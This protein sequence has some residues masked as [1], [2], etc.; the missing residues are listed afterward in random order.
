MKEKI[1]EIICSHTYIKREDLDSIGD[2]DKLTELG[3]DSINVVYI[4]GEI[5]E[6]FN[7]SFYDEDMLL[8]NFETI[9]KI[10]KTVG[11]Y[12]SVKSV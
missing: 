1:K 12:V 11:K 3:L 9:D 5:E 6:E 8:V 10:L 4:I 2:N 7:F